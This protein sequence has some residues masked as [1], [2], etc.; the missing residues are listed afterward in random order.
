[1]SEVALEKNT[2]WVGV[3][4]RTTDLFEG[5]WPIE[6]IGV[7]YNSYIIKDDKNVLIDLAK[8]IKTD[9]FFNQISR[10]VDIEKLD[11]VIVNHMEP[12]HTG[13]IK[14]L[15]MIAKNVQILCTPKAVAM[16]QDYYGVQEGIVTVED[17]ETLSTGNH[18][19]QFFH[20]PFVHWP[21]TMVTFDST[22]KVLFSCD[23]FGG[24]GAFH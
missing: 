18:T 20:V 19:L 17:G 2:Y 6:G 14:T 16:L 11:Y 10:I 4:D 22:T 23:A 3:N 21:E 12:D 24:Y 13:V 7:S 9:D 1:M 15:R 8:G 5:L